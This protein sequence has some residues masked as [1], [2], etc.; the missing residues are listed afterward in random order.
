MR[1]ILFGGSG[2]VGQ[3]VQR[4]CLR[5]PGV[6]D[7]LSVVRAPTGQLD[8]KLHE[9]VHADFFDFA[10]LAARFTGYDACFFCLG[11]TS[12]GKSEAQYTRVTYDITMAAATAL[13]SV[14]PHMTFVLVSGAG[15][16]SSAR[17]RIMWARVKGRA[18]NGVLALPFQGY[19]FR[20]ALI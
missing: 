20:P 11:V 19:V 16:D 5:D 4:E 2:M 17:G 3:G 6:T 9:L 12:A 13:A 7:V 1:V 18:E 15:A 10:P 8:P 14:N